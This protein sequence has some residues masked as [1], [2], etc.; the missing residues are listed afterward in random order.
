GTLALLAGHQPL[1]LMTG[2]RMPMNL[3]LLKWLAII[4]PLLFLVAV[5][6]LRHI[7]FQDQPYSP[8]SVV[9]FFAILAVAIF[10]FSHSV[11]S[12]I[13]GLQ[14]RVLAQNTHLA[15]L[16]SIATAAAESPGLQPLLDT[17]LEQVLDIL[18]ADAGL[19]CVVDLEAEEHSAV[20]HRGFS[21]ELVH[22][23]Q[24]AKLAD[25][26]FAQ[27]AV[28]TGR[29]LV[30]EKVFE[31][32]RVAEAARSEGVRSTITVPLKAEGEVTGILAI[33]TV[34]ERYFTPS[35][36]ELLVSVGGQLGMAIR[37]ATLFQRSLQRNREM[38]ALLAVSR[39]GASSL[40]LPRVLDRALDTILEVTSA[41]AAEMWLAEERGELTLTR[42]RGAASEAFHEQ[43][44]FQMGEGFPGLA[45]QTCSPVVVHDLSRDPRF[46]R[47][48]V[49]EAGFQ[50]YCALPLLHRER[51][52]GVLGVAARA[53]EA[54][55]RPEELRLL[56]GIG[57]VIA[58]AIE[59]ARL[60]E[61]VQDAAVLEERERIAREMHDGLAQVLG[62][63][64]TQ[65]LAIK[66]LL[67]SGHAAE[68]RETL[69]Q[70]EE[71]ARQVY[72]DV[73]EAILGLRT[74][75]GS[76]GE[77]VPSLQR[78][79]EL[80]QEMTGLRAQMR[81]SGE[82]DAIKLPPAMEIQLMRIVQEALSNVRRHA[83]AST[84]TVSFE[85]DGQQLQVAVEDDGQG[86][87]PEQLPPRDW[88]RFGLQTMQERAEAV[89]GRFRIQSRPGSGTSVIVQLP[90]G[91]GESAD[92]RAAGR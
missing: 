85:M 47:T 49:K 39:A 40:D 24:R 84:V 83:R 57:E 52:V 72:A 11:F 80:Y 73:R 22:R 59:N 28:R 51:L 42:H 13:T 48:G 37:N 7:L 27:E 65:S 53:Q 81:V 67:A 15:V 38:E 63:I 8:G 16:N 76:E 43:T 10:L 86:F 56:V 34:R 18:R 68:A 79:L 74:S 45:A 19:I 9:F 55:T 12:L 62:Y 66:R 87:E 71:A 88:P 6:I 26:P 50:T 3:R 44:R 17:A 25:D 5:D 82:P 21:P 20:A 61:R 64:N 4:L 75:P 32:P 69:T 60:Y 2:W 91:M 70:M 92:A 1:T 78:Y 33:A 31:D 58:V 30:V 36:L 41:E 35:D 77:L 29:P 23:I 46:L 14:H 54:L 89:G 90:M